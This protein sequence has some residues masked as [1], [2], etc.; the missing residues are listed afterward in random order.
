MNNGSEIALQY[1]F[2]SVCCFCFTTFLIALIS[3]GSVT[4]NVREPFNPTVCKAI[5]GQPL[6]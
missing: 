2:C 1:L 4:S 6:R 5:G 3:Y